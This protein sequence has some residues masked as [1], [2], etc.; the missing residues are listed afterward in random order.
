M[1]ITNGA[2]HEHREPAS[3][4][5]RARLRWRF[6]APAVLLLLTDGPSHGYELL[7]RLRPMLPADAA[8]P[9]P[10]ALYRLLRGLEEEGALR[11]SWADNPGS[12]PARRV[13][14]LTDSGRGTLDGWAF[15]IA[16]EIQAMSGLL[17]RYCG[18]G[19]FIHPQAAEVDQ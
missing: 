8:P 5:G 2:D 11:S 17:A 14:E 3:L 12:G 10:S 9:D 16:S 13:Y 18:A 6:T 15:S 19:A 1:S 7:S 4:P